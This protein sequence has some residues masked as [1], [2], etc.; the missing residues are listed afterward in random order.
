[1][2]KATVNNKLE[3]LIEGT[4]TDWD[5]VQ[6]RENVFHII[7]HNKC[8]TATLV[9]YNTDEKSMVLNINGTDYDVSIKDKTDLLLQKL[10]ISNV[11]TKA[12]QHIKAPM[13][14]LI[15]SIA[16]TAGDVVHK[17]DPLL[18][19]EAMK[20]ENAIKSPRDG[21]IK[22]VAVQPRQAVEK[23]QLLIEFE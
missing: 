7:R 10:G 16:V 14:G 11:S 2:L 4:P 22:R 13:P 12:V 5:I 3:V 19:L 8:Y 23:N 21:V 6:V 20:M 9:S 18:I 17:G 1:M 15:V